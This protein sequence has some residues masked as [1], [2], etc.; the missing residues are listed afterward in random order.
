TVRGRGILDASAIPHPGR[1]MLNFRDARGITIAGVTL[2][3]AANW[4]FVI[5]SSENVT[6]EDVRII[7][8]RLNSDGI[9]S[10]NARGVRIRGCFVRNHDDSIVVKTTRPDLPAED[11]QVEDCVIWND[12]GYALGVSYETR[13]PISNVTFTRCAILFARHW[14]MGVHVSDGATIR[15]VT[16]RDIAYSGLRAPAAGAYAAL[17]GEPMLLKLSI[18]ED[19]WGHDP[20]R[21][22]IRDILLDGVTIHGGVMPASLLEGYDAEHDIRGVTFRDVRL[23]GEPPARTLAD[24]RVEPMR[25]AEEVTVAES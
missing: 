6:V 18:V 9:N 3:D 10:V 11:I 17:A 20:E 25:F 12:W 23:A 1:S 22:R 15:G 5:G 19:V 4:N 14:C 2:R 7:S 21:G 24:L 13:S 16:F 8:G